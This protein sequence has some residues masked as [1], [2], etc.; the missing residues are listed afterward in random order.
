[1]YIYVCVKNTDCVYL[2][3]EY[4]S[5]CFVRQTANSPFSYDEIK[6]N[7]CS[8]LRLFPCDVDTRDYW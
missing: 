1:M 2:D 6:V 3:D 5:E 8:S 4:C 7:C